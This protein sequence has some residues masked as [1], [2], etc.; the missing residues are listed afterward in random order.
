MDVTIPAA[1]D[2]LES[3]NHA[4]RQD[5]EGMADDDSQQAALTYATGA[6]PHAHP[7]AVV[8]DL[9]GGGAALRLGLHANRHR[10]ACGET[11]EWTVHGA[12]L[13]ISNF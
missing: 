5:V 8:F 7:S 9:F 11:F 6:V 12:A 4:N 3:Q 13:C 2:M 10:P 1:E